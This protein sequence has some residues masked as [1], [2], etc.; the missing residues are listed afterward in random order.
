MASTTPLTEE[1]RFPGIVG[2][3]A[4]G[5][6]SPRMYDAGPGHLGID[7]L[8]VPC[9]I[10]ASELRRVV[11]AMPPWLQALDGKVGPRGRHEEGLAVGAVTVKIASLPPEG[12]DS[13]L[14]VA[15]RA[16]RDLDN[17]Q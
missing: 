15:P 2:S 11:R 5:T 12:R 3:P 10:Q 9:E 8:S 17:S 1:P 16:P 4:K 13:S 7:A 14:P 6:L